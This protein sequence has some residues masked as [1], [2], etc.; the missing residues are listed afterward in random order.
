MRRA[1]I[2][3]LALLA[4]STG[5]AQTP[6]PTVLIEPAIACHRWDGQLVAPAECYNVFLPMVGDQWSLEGDKR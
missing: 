1:V 6:A 3:L 2:V 5:H 4:A